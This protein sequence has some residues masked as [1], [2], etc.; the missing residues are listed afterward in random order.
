MKNKLGAAEVGLFKALILAV[1][2]A[3]VA[4]A[5]IAYLPL[6]GPPALRMLTMKS[7]KLT[8]M[9]AVP[10]MKIELSTNLATGDSNCPDIKALNTNMT[11]TVVN[12]AGDYAPTLPIL[13]M[14][15]DNPLGVPNGASIFNLP[16][17]DTMGITPQILATYFQPMISGTN[18]TAV[19]GPFR[20]GFIPPFAQPDKSSHAEYIVK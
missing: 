20:V 13:V 5:G 10:A 16:A 4:R 12:S 2:V 15:P 14:G 7:P 8:P 1:G 18:G 9:I 17:Q 3:S 11:A 6:T 19:A